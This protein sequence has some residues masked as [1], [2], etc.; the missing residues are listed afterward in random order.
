[1]KQYFV[2]IVRCS[3]SSYYTGVTNDLLGR[4]DEHQ[5]GENVNCYTFKRR[6]L[7]LV[8]Y[9]RF[10]DINQAIAFEKQVKGWRRAKKE[11]LI[12]NRWDLLPELSKTAK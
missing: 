6:P 3:D 11:A 12:N 7:E 1:M 2:Y 4:F 5:N 9:E 10:E 8:F